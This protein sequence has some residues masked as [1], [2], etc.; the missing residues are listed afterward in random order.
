[1]IMN[2][3]KVTQRA[4]RNNV[5]GWVKTSLLVFGLASAVVVAITVAEERGPQRMAIAASM[6]QG[7]ESGASN[8]PQPPGGQMSPDSTPIARPADAASV[9]IDESRECRPEQGIVTSCTFD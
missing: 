4:S 1:M 6:A 2:K 3:D 8:A 7:P 5:P 9:S